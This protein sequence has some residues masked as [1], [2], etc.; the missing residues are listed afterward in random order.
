MI[1]RL[2]KNCRKK[3]LHLW[4]RLDTDATINEITHLNR[5]ELRE[6]IVFL[7]QSKS[8]TVLMNEDANE[9]PTKII[10]VVGE[11]GHRRN[12]NGNNS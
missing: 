4:A 2:P 6:S 11:A 10:S 7:T 8:L 3:I 1:H 9:L 5:T 12:H